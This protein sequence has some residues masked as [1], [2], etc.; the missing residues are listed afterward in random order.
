MKERFIS[1]DTNKLQPW[2]SR[3][4]ERWKREGGAGIEV[5]AEAAP[6]LHSPPSLFFS[7]SFSSLGKIEWC[8]HIPESTA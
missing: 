3:R 2:A 1:K 6:S 7:S 5:E 8:I 4:R